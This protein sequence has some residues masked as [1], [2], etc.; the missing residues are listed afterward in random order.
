MHQQIRMMI[1]QWWWF[2]TVTELTFFA[3]LIVSNITHFL[4]GITLKIRDE[5]NNF[6]M[7]QKVERVANH[8]RIKGL[9]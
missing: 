5:L 2:I 9:L 1:G 3:G 6:L 7:P 4:G 8:S